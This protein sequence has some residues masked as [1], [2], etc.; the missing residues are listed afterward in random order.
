MGYLAQHQLFEQI[1]EL[2][3]DIDTP[4]YCSLGDGAEQQTNAWFGPPNTVSPLHHDPHHNLLAQALGYKYVR[5]YA[6]AETPRLYVH[7][8]R[9]LCN[10]SQADIGNLDLARFP[11]L[12]AAAF[13]D[14]L[15]RPGDMLYI[16]PGHWH[17]V[18]A[19]TASFSVSFWWS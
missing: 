4:P 7:G 8:E 9:L 16:P 18:R 19:L 6:P 5:L 12:A 15:L 10:T 1:P 14:V 3:E 17:Y 2:A 13:Q 11:L